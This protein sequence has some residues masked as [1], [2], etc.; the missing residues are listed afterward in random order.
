MEDS[1][2][3]A[4][5]ESQQ[6]APPDRRHVRQV[7][8]RV[9]RAVVG[10]GLRAEDAVVA[11]V[12]GGPDSMALLDCLLAARRRGGPAVH[13]A[14]LNHGLRP[15]AETVADAVGHYARDAGLPVTVGA[16][17]EYPVAGSAGEA[18]EDAARRARW[19]FLRDVARRAG[20]ARIATG[21]TRNDQAETVVMNLARGAGPRGLSGMRADDGE[22]LRPL[23]T[24]S[25]DDIAAYV[26]ALQLPVDSDPLNATPR[27]RRNRIRREALPLL[28]DIYPGAVNA[29]ARSAEILAGEI[30]SLPLYVQPADGL[31]MPLHLGRTAVTEGAFPAVVIA[32]VRAMGGRRQL[33][34]AQLGAVARALREDSHGRWVDLTEGA[35]AFVRDGAVVVYP[36]RV[37]DGAWQPPVPLAVPGEARVPGGSVIAELIEGGSPDERGHATDGFILDHDRLQGRTLTLR[38]PA[39]HERVPAESSQPPRDL[40]RLLRGRGVAADIAP[41][42]PVL[43]VDGSAACVPG[44]WR[45]GDFAPGPN[46]ARV[47]ALHACWDAIPTLGARA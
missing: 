22:I 46:A 4:N 26:K 25:R 42:M 5:S 10:A 12:S 37:R 16:P 32:A 14:H 29:I 38:A 41:A 21:H 8:D 45:H 27:F 6:A 36:E 39:P 35:H 30:D 33:G 40:S 23:L 17:T 34:A 1:A 13:V 44:V 47:V 15:D 20:A 9:F 18:S 43:D 31:R 11:A 24:V 2:A 7:Q 19:T 3:R 28:D